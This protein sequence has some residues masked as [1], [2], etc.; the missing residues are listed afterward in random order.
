MIFGDLM[1]TALPKI[2]KRMASE[3]LEASGETPK[4][5]EEAKKLTRKIKAP[6]SKKM[7]NLIAGQM[8]RILKKK[9]KD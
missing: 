9:D 5:Y 8:V 3:T 2:F 7:R 6:F 4:D 1:G